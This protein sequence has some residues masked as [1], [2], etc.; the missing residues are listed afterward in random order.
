MLKKSFLLSCLIFL[1]T[2]CGQ[3]GPL[4]LPTS[5]Q[6]TSHENKN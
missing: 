6:D 4:Y 3:S 2:A 1:L 5:S